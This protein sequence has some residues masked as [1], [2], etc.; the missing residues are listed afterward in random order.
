M[1]AGPL[2]VLEQARDQD[3]LA[4]GDRIDV[5]LDALEIAV[6]PDRSIGVDDG[7]RRELP[8]EVVGRVSEVDRQAADDE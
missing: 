1:D 7:R 2:D 6:D 3:R 8:D 4:V 5:D